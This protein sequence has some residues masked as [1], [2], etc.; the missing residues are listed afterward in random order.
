MEPSPSSDPHEQGGPSS[1]KNVTIALISDCP[2]LTVHA[3]KCYKALIESGAAI[4]LV[5]YSMYDNIDDHVKSYTVN[6][7]IP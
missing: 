6:I 5:I 1:N 7:N 3:G 4:S 2:T